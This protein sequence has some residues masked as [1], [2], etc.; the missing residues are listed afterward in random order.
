MFLED[1]IFDTTFIDNVYSQNI[2]FQVTVHMIS[3]KQEKLFIAIL[4]FF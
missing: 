1:I 3:T 4:L 2:L